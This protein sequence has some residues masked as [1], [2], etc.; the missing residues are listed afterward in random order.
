MSSFTGLIVGIALVGLYLIAVGVCGI[1]AAARKRRGRNIPVICV[2]FVQ[3]RIGVVLRKDYDTASQK[4]WQ[5]YLE[6]KEKYDF[7]YITQ[8]QGCR[9]KVSPVFVFD[10]LSKEYA[11]LARSCYVEQAVFDVP[12][13]PKS[14][15]DTDTMEAA[16]LHIFGYQWGHIFIVG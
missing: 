12:H 6:G 13:L 5:P 9:L 3:G 10:P 11:T 4:Y 7:G 8:P 15:D 16:W 14:M 2:C 1:V